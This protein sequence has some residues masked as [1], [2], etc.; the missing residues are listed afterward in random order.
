M[1]EIALDVNGNIDQKRLEKSLRN[2]LDFDI[3]YRQ[4]DNMKKKACKVS[5]DYDEFKAMVDCAHLKRVSRKE[6]ESLS[7]TKQGWAKSDASGNRGNSANIL[8]EELEK[9][10]KGEALLSKKLSA[11]C[12]KLPKTPLEFGRDLRR[13][14][15][16]SRRFRYVLLSTQLIY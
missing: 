10:E 4:R 8:N 6:I 5:S 7:T 16:V 13:L 11:S 1:T 14:S 12:E 3:K 15:D 9:N 2:A